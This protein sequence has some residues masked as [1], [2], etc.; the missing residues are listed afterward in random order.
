MPV[1][2]VWKASRALWLK[3]L[4]LGTS[5]WT[6]WHQVQWR[7]PA[8]SSSSTIS[9]PSHGPVASRFYSHGHD[10]GL[11]G[12]VG[13][14]LRPAGEV[15]RAGWGGAGR[16]LP[17]GV[18]LRD[19][20]CAGGGRRTAAR[21]VRTGRLKTCTFLREKSRL[22]SF[23]SLTLIVLIPQ[24]TVYVQ[25]ATKTVYVFSQCQL[26]HS[27]YVPRNRLQAL[28]CGRTVWRVTYIQFIESCVMVMQHVKSL[29]YSV[30]ISEII[31]PKWIL[32]N[33]YLI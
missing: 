3:R 16:R 17:A 11:K 21:H 22:K 27:K 1:K 8:L 23:N 30:I 15:R 28:A 14:A 20:T 4:R 29:N 13:P 19:G 33:L 26:V 18:A 25:T 6:C 24:H 5:G 7:P 12:W 31:G 2:P 32:Q 9:N 10:G